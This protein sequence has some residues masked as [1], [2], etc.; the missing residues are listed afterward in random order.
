ME[1]LRVG[2]VGAGLI[3]NR[4]ADVLGTFDDVAIVG[5]CD[6]HR[7]RAGALADRAGAALFSDAHELL[8]RAQVDAIF[9]C[10][11]PFAHGEPER[12]AIDFA[13]P[14]FVEK[15]IGTDVATADAVSEAVHREGVL[16]GVGYHWRYLDTFDEAR[17][18]LV[19]RPARLAVGYWLDATPPPPWWCLQ[20]MSG[21][22]MVEQATHVLDLA[23][24]LIG[25]VTSVY[26]ASARTPRVE[27]A[28]ADI[29]D[30]STATLRFA[31]GAV[32]SVSSTCL[33][34]WRHRVAIH[35][36]C[37]SLAIE[38][39]EFDISVDVGQ[40]ASP[41]RA[42]GDPLARQDRA[43]LD[44][45]RGRPNRIRVSYAEALRTHRL[46]CAIAQSAA[47]GAPVSVEPAGPSG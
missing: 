12:A 3:A 19:D 25:E 11:P 14:F 34:D 31:T 45:V 18:L 8:D 21:G 29:A 42:R 13:T 17:E 6:P 26:A 44:A 10:V 1:Q 7:E 33:L 35:L 5:V 46:A 2:L 32:G 16:T 41:R 20:D 37:E 39:S 23:R 30:V 47:E 43:F 4:H 36:F 24:C 22:Q 9:I 27:F 28:G 40:G 15:P 38:L